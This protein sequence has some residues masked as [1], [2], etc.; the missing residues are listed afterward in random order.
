MSPV[1]SP[2][3]CLKAFYICGTEMWYQV[4]LS[5]P[6]ELK[7]QK[8]RQLEYGIKSTRNE[9]ATEQTCRNSLEFLADIQNFEQTPIP[10]ERKITGKPD[11]F[12]L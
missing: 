1:I 8:L 9:R 3:S 7:R 5:G 4:L 2:A 12:K 11:S 10:G 6:V